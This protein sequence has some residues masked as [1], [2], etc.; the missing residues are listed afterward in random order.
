MSTVNNDSFLTIT[1]Q[2]DNNGIMF[3]N[4]H[5]GLRRTNINETKI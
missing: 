4:Y 5:F 2:S 3:K 1:T